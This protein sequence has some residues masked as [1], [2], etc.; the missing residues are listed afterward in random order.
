SGGISPQSSADALH[1]AFDAGAA[2]A[3]GGFFRAATFDP[4]QTRLAPASR[5]ELTLDDGS[6]E[7]I[8][9][10]VTDGFRGFISDVPIRSLDIRTLDLDDEG[11]L[12]WA[13]LD[14]L[15]VG[16]PR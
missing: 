8:D 16:A 9:A 6:V 15:F 1:V 14:E 5:V 3:V 11:N 13:L 10:P 2:R 4:F 12:P 7:T